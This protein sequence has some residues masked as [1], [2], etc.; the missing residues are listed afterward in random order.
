MLVYRPSRGNDTVTLTYNGEWTG[1]SIGREVIIRDKFGPANYFY[2]YYSDLSS[3]S[4]WL[5]KPVTNLDF[6]TGVTYYRAIYIGPDERENIQEYIGTISSS[7]GTCSTSSTSGDINVSLWNEGVF[8]LNSSKN[9][10]ALD[11]ELDTTSKLVSAGASFTSS[12]NFN[13]TLNVGDWIKIWIKINVPQNLSLVDVDDLCYTVNIGNLSINISRELSRLSMSQVFHGNIQSGDIVLK[14]LIPR[15]SNVQTVQKVINID[16]NQTHIFYNSSDNTFK[17]LII[18]KH[19][20]AYDNKF[21]D[22]DLSNVTNSIT[23]FDLTS[24]SYQATQEVYSCLISAN[25][26]KYIVDI[27]ETHLPDRK[28]FYVF[29]NE[30]KQYDDGLTVS[31][32]AETYNKYYANYGHNTYYWASGVILLDFN[33]FGKETFE[34]VDAGYDNRKFSTNWVGV[35]YSL[36]ENFFLTSVSH[37]DDLFT[38]IGYNTENSFQTA[39]PSGTNGFVNKEKNYFT[40]LMFTWEK[41]ILKGEINPQIVK[42]PEISLSNTIEERSKNTSQLII[43]N[44]NG[45]NNFDLTHYKSVNNILTSGGNDI[46]YCDLGSPQGN[47]L[48]HYNDASI[49]F[50]TEDNLEEWSSTFAFRMGVVASSAVSLSGFYSYSTNNASQRHII[51]VNNFVTITGGELTTLPLMTTPSSIS[52]N[53]TIFVLNVKNSDYYALE[54]YFNDNI[55]TLSVISKDSSGNNFISYTGGH[56]L[57]LGQENVITVNTFKKQI[58]D[59]GDCIGKCFVN[60]QLYFNGDYVCEG[61]TYIVN[62]TDELVLTYNPRKQFSGSLSYFE[63]NEYLDKPSEYAKSLYNIHSN[64][65]W[66]RIL[67]DRLNTNNPIKEL[68]TYKNK[69]IIYLNNLPHSKRE[70]IVPIVLLGSGYQ[71][72]NYKNYNSEVIR[73]Y[74]DLYSEQTTFDFKL[75][76]LNNIDLAFTILGDSTLLDWS[77]DE[78]DIVNDRLV[79]WVK[80]PKYTGQRIVMYYNSQKISTLN[81]TPKNA[82][83][84]LYGV[85][86]MN[87]FDTIYNLRFLDQKIFNAG[88]NIVYLQKNNEKYLIQIDYQY[89]TGYINTYKSNKF[90]IEYDDRK[91]IPEQMDVLESF[92]REYGELFKPDYM[93][94][95]KVR[96]KFN[97]RLESNQYIPEELR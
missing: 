73:T 11:N 17:D 23:G 47:K 86:T 28:Y 34:E 3:D 15:T 74:D 48:K 30:L 43:D 25:N 9:S 33:C 24:Q 71:M 20:N 26:P 76:N 1:Q 82:F 87:K 14:E 56:K 90:N 65:Y 51:D 32:S 70:L 7:V 89:M 40:E 10:I 83:N 63:V 57:L 80:I 35:D 55:D 67:P 22:V 66:N 68:Q 21:I 91:V 6:S 92:I 75:I 84:S 58:N 97:Y 18:E 42:T 4:S 31:T 53:T 95:S 38:A 29:Y 27:F 64:I 49:S 61:T 39:I 85:W 54:M 13:N 36:K 94:I 81:D 8:S 59:Y 93:S 16:D 44:W 5:F 60:Y 62:S 37:Q 2:W 19:N 41:D 88:E 12:I 52:G 78:Y 77:A 96:S 46:R 69:R 45:I 79:V 50:D 72:S